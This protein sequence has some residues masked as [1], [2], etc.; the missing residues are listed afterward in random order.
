MNENERQLGVVRH[1][2]PT[3]HYGWILPR[4]GA[5]DVFVHISALIDQN[6][7][8][9]EGL[10]VSFT[11][12]TDKTGRP[13]ATSVKIGGIHERKPGTGRHVDACK[14]Y[15]VAIDEQCRVS[16]W[17]EPGPLGMM[18]CVKIDSP[19]LKEWVDLDESRDVL[20]FPASQ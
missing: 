19:T 3:H 11:V 13:Q 14:V 4:S 16:W 17:F 15:S 18:A 1:W 5:K 9:Y 6:E 7:D 12:G 8:L 2:K 10:H 20:K